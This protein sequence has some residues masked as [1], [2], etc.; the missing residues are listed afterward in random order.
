MSNLP[1]TGMFYIPTLT[2]IKKG[3]N[4]QDFTLVVKV[5][6]YGTPPPVFTA[7]D[8]I[9][10]IESVPVT[11]ASAEVVTPPANEASPETPAN[12]VAETEKVGE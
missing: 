5:A 3:T 9:K 1:R 8:A 4:A 2:T 7:D 10:A 11:A 6:P 12:P